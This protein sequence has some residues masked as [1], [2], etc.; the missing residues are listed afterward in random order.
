[1][2]YQKNM[3]LL[4]R[5]IRLIVGSLFIYF[6]FFDRSVITDPFSGALVGI[7]GI[8]MMVASMFAYCPAYV[9]IGLSTIRRVVSRA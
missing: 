1:V 9:L 4:D 7:V 3:G 5:G 2:A 6:G 8:V